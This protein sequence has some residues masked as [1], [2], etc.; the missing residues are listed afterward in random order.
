M[1]SAL[2]S[3]N[4]EHSMKKTAI[5]TGG[6]HG[7]GCAVAKRL[8]QDG[9]GVVVNYRSNAS[10]AEEVESEIQRIGGNGIAAKADA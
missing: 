7:I 10:E 2:A 6:C 4:T 8:A 5:V 3:K 1:P 9:F